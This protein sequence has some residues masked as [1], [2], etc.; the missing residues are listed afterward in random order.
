MRI[1]YVGDVVDGR[2]VTRWSILC[3]RCVGSTRS[4]WWS[5]TVRTPRAAKGSRSRLLRACCTRR[6][7]PRDRQPRLAVPRVN[8]YLE[9]EPRLLRPANYPRAPGHGS[10]VH[11][12]TD[13]RALGVIQVEG[14]VFMRSLDCPFELSRPRSSASARLSATLVD[15]HCEATSEKQALAWHFAGRVS[16]LIGSHTHVQTA[17][18][19]ILQAARLF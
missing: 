17:D 9:R 19:R 4:T 7:R 12:L 10:Y 2:A 5:S 15:V 8:D 18:E 1:L 14:R 6:R 3:R 11:T 16:A 13:G